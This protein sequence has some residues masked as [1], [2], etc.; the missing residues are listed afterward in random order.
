MIYLEDLAGLDQEPALSRLIEL[1]YG[2]DPEAFLSDLDSGLNRL[3]RTDLGQAA[4]Y[5]EQAR[6]LSNSIHRKYEG[7]LVSLSARLALWSGDYTAALRLYQQALKLFEKYRQYEAAARLHKGTIEVLMYLGR[8]DE[9]LDSGRKA[10]RFFR[11]KEML[12]DEAQTLTNIGNVYHRMDMNHEALR[13]YDK[14]RKIFEPTGGVPLAVVDYN[15][16][17]IHANLNHLQQAR[18]LYAEA[19]NVYREQGLLIAES[20]ANYSVAYLLFLEDR[21]TEAMTLF[22]HVYEKFQELGDRKS[23]AVTQLDLVELNVQVNQFGMAMM[24]GEACLPELLKLKMNYEAAKAHYFVAL[25]RLAMEDYRSAGNRLK[26]AERMFEAEKNDLWLGLVGVARA[27]LAQKQGEPAE[28]AEAAEAAIAKFSASHDRRREIDARLVLLQTLYESN[29]LDKA[30]SQLRRLRRAKLAGYQKYQL[31]AIIADFYFRRGLFEQAS[32]Y[33]REAVMVVEQMLT[34]L[35]R[36]D[37]RY[38]FAVDKYHSYRRLVESLLKLGKTQESFIQSLNALNMLNHPTVSIERLQGEV[39]AALI[40]KMDQLRTTLTRLYKFPRSGERSTVDQADYREVEQ[41]LFYYHRRAVSHSSAKAV[42]GQ[43][44]VTPETLLRRLRKQKR[45]LVVYHGDDDSL[46][47]FVANGD[48]VVYVSLDC[49]TN[50]V[51]GLVRKLHFLAERTVSHRHEA[52]STTEACEYYL[53]RIYAL[54][55]A[56]LLSHCRR[57]EIVFVPSGVLMQVPFMALCDESGR[58]LKDDRGIQ[59]AVD[60]LQPPVSSKGAYNRLKS[61]VFAVDSEELPLVR[62]EG[63]Q[64]SR[65]F[66]N[67]KFYSA[68]RASS[69]HLMRELVESKGFVHV[70]AHAS[71]SS[72]NPLFSRILLADGP[73]FPFDL[74]DSGVSARLVTLSGCQTAAPGLYYGNSF[75]LA[76]AFHQ[77]GSRQV[78]ASLWP[79]A[80]EVTERFMTDFYR[81]LKKSGSVVASYRETINDMHRWCCNPALWGAY[82]LIGEE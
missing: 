38:F 82:I 40:E 13:Y 66:D 22:E 76:R 30:D 77:A 16:A 61:A 57:D 52:V 45:S 59:I 4:K 5:V 67:A 79:V 26:Q 12:T 73:Y 58:Y 41:Q 17:N 20:Q 2:G 60:P 1:K 36:D 10:L 55:V 29:Q 80:D 65:I 3:I 74:F 14:A 47:A 68:K 44:G 70:A 15:R 8:Y 9:A 28:A 7:R 75:S 62:K 27:R 48:G 54:L 50:E 23:A 39:P 11:R 32:R 42:S 37:L 53:G 6:K 34:G 43:N 31:N 81:R 46:G 21:Y 24:L 49:C 33:Y 63:K 72:E 69:V 19:A 78:L 35:H 51:E 64:I 25:A 18:K 71:R 56:P